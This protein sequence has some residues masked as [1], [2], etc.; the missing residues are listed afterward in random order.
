M[1]G[2][3][4]WAQTPRPPNANDEV[5]EWHTLDTTDFNKLNSMQKDVDMIITGYGTFSDL[6]APCKNYSSTCGKMAP[7]EP[8]CCMPPIRQLKALLGGYFTVQGY[9]TATVASVGLRANPLCLDVLKPSSARIFCDVLGAESCPQGCYGGVCISGQCISVSNLSCHDVKPLCNVLSNAGVT[10]RRFC[11]VT[12]GCRESRSVLLVP[13]PSTGCPS[14]C[15]ESVQRDL[16]SHA[17]CTDEP[18]GSPALAG[19]AG[20]L[21]SAY[22]PYRTAEAFK[23]VGR[24]L[25]TYGCHFMERNANEC[26]GF[27]DLGAEYGVEGRTPVRAPLMFCPVSCKCTSSTP[28]CASACPAKVYLTLIP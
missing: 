8:S 3:M 5:R 4:V 20:L 28:G 12:C 21:R 7:K 23:R 1:N 9:N 27:D 19:Y 18:K 22:L 24:G 15:R 25:E 16:S 17:N 26:G 11:S 2:Q 6:T 14:S 13:N 10:A